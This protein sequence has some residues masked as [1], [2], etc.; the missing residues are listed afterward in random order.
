[1]KKILTTLIIILFYSP[2]FSQTLKGFVRDEKGIGLKIPITLRD[3]TLDGSIVEVFYPEENGSFEYHLSET[4]A[5]LFIHLNPKNFQTYTDSIIR[6]VKSGVYKYDIVLKPREF[7]LQEV[8]VSAVQKVKVKGDTLEYNASKLLNG[9]ERRLKELLQ[10]LPGIEMSSNGRMKY[11]GKVVE[12]LQLDGDDLFEQNYGIATKNMDV[13]LVDKV[14]IINKFNANPILKRFQKSNT[15]GINLILKKSK[16][17]HNLNV[18]GGLGAGDKLFHDVSVD[19]LSVKKGLKAYGNFSANNVSQEGNENIDATD[20]EENEVHDDNFNENLPQLGISGIN[21]RINNDTFS[22]YHL[23][24]RPVKNWSSKFALGYTNERLFQNYLD[25]QKSKLL[26]FDFYDLNQGNYLQNT[27]DIENS[28]IVNFHKNGFLKLKFIWVG[29]SNQSAGVLTQNENTKLNKSIQRTED[30]I[31]LNLD[32]SVTLDSNLALHA[33]G[34]YYQSTLFKNSMF[35]NVPIRNLQQKLD[36]LEAILH[37]E[38]ELLGRVKSLKWGIGLYQKG[39]NHDLSSDFKKSNDDIYGYNSRQNIQTFGVKKT[40]DLTLENL[41]FNGFLDFRWAN[42]RL[43]EKE[44]L[45]NPFPLYSVNL[46]FKPSSLHTINLNATNNLKFNSLENLL[47]RETLLDTRISGVYDMSL[48]PEK[49]QE[50]GLSYQFNEPIS[51]FTISGNY[52]RS[53]TSNAYQS[54]IS[55]DD[56]LNTTWYFRDP[57]TF[58]GGI[59]SIDMQKLFSSLQSSLGIN[60]IRIEMNMLNELDQGVKRS[61]QSF[62]DKLLTFFKTSFSLP[63]GIENRFSYSSNSYF[64]NQQ[65]GSQMANWDNQL[66]L[67]YIFQDKIKF[68]SDYIYVCPNTQEN[69]RLEI[70]DFEV[71]YLPK[72]GNLEW[73]FSL[74]GKNITN[75]QN[76]TTR[77]VNDYAEST[78]SFQLLGAVYMLKA[79]FKF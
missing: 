8:V 70:Y 10:K 27:Y 68:Q 56:F 32:Y 19:I 25:I 67:Y 26:N 15:V 54:K 49:K 34:G 60:L 53:F 76:F 12:A 74:L 48:D 52:R 17:K 41:N 73:E 79:G 13:D 21:S 64:I 43:N 16:L 30:K 57:Q 51:F 22:S 55:S 14:Q 47:I 9:T 61:I 69:V 62:N 50:I 11:M 71:S 1:M 33:T 77:M 28:N 24:F 75:Q 38:V 44:K 3:S 65:S 58:I 63:F 40:L 23:M 29:K 4:Y 46:E 39:I 2:L 72:V 36:G 18:V 37:Q 5:K 20:Y 45:F 31:Q 7:E 78:S 59:Y 35:S 66:K 6:P 42:I